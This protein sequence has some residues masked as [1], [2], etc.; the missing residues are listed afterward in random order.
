MKTGCWWSGAY[1]HGALLS[2]ERGEADV[3]LPNSAQSPWRWVCA[4]TSPPLVTGARKAGALSG[5]RG[6]GWLQHRLW[7]PRCSSRDYGYAW[8]AERKR[9]AGQFCSHYAPFPSASWG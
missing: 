5:E 3:G 9:R 8:E 4:C 1:V 2:T 6:P 7:G